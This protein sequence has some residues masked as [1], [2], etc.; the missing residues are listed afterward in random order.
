MNSKF[1]RCKN[2]ATYNASF[3]NRIREK[4]VNSGYN[5]SKCNNEHSQRQS[6]RTFMKARQIRYFAP[7]RNGSNSSSRVSQSQTYKNPRC[8]STGATDL[9]A[10][11]RSCRRD[12]SPLATFYMSISIKFVHDKS[13]YTASGP[14]LKRLARTELD[15]R[16]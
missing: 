13:C 6:L 14:H 2:L 4:N 16:G 11:V 12:K 3:R 8:S 7:K 9:Y 10:T 5:D 15:D 1:A